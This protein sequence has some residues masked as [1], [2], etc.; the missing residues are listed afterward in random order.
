[1]SL[2]I[3]FFWTPCNFKET[4]VN[5]LICPYLYD[6]PKLYMNCKLNIEYILRQNL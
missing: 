6:N 3:T 4:T 5:A 1:M 2:K